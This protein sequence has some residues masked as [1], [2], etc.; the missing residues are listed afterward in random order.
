MFFGPVN[1]LLLQKY[2]LL[3]KNNWHFLTILVWELNSAGVWIFWIVSPLLLQENGRKQKSLVCEKFDHLYAILED[4][5]REMSVTVT[6]EQEEKVNYIRGLK[7]KY[8]DHVERVTKIV[9]SGIQMMG[10]P[11]MAVFLQ[12]SEIPLSSFYIVIVMFLLW[13]F[14]H[15]S[16]YS[17][18]YQ[19]TILVSPQEDVF[20]P[21]LLLH[22]RIDAPFIVTCKTQYNR[23][24]CFIVLI[25][26]YLIKLISIAL[27]RHDY[28]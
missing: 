8:E 2:L 20:I 27:F 17:N 26:D 9:E 24:I 19:G 16:E 18:M 28:S 15:R 7:R 11:E 4:R 1:M 13:V 5:K 10:E 6:A 23:C 3:Q 21:N 22:R 25:Y 12:V 14:S